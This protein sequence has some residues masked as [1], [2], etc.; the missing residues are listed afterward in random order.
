MYFPVLILL[1]MFFRL[2]RWQLGGLDGLP[3]T[4][5]IL[6]EGAISGAGGATG[7]LLLGHLINRKIDR[8]PGFNPDK[9]YFKII[10]YVCGGV[11][12]LLGKLYVRVADPPLKI[13]SKNA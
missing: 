8:D 12:A 6:I 1:G 7:I 10:P 9:W 13:G 4:Y 5:V 11:A 3:F 2:L